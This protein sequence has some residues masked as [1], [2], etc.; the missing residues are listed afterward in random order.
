MRNEA[1][2]ILKKYEAIDEECCSVEGIKVANDE[3]KQLLK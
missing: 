3:R 1:I 2:E